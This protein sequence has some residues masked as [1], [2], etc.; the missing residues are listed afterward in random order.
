VGWLGRLKGVCLRGPA[1]GR[2]RIFWTPNV[3][4]KGGGEDMRTFILHIPPSLERSPP[5]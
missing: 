5:P 3:G 4:A 2:P 1:R